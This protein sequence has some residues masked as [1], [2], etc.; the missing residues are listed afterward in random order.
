MNS[1]YNFVINKNNL[2][3]NIENLKSSFSNYSDVMIDLSNNAFNHGLAIV[4]DYYKWGINNY[5][6]DNLT[7]AIKIRS[8]NRYIGIWCSEKI[9]L[10]YI[11]DAINN[12]IVVRIYSLEYLED[13]QGLNLKDDL[14]IEL[15]ISTSKKFPGLKNIKDF[16]NA[17]KIVEQEKHLILKSVT[18]I[19]DDS[20]I[21]SLDFMNQ[22]NEFYKYVKLIDNENIKIILDEKCAF[23]KKRNY[24]NSMV[25]KTLQYGLIINDSK[26]L[27]QKLKDKREIKN[28]NLKNNLNFQL[29]P[30]FLI[31]SY[32][33]DK[34]V[35]EKKEVFLNYK[36]KE[37]C[38]IGIV[39]IGKKIGLDETI[40]YVLINEKKCPILKIEY[41]YLY[42]ILN[43]ENHI[44][45]IVHLFGDNLLDF[46]N[47]DS[48]TFMLKFNN[49]CKIK[50]IK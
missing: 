24:V 14:K 49:N 40:E 11:Y 47:G 26:N 25:L 7:E 35:V 36:F 15:L 50:Y 38:E 2:K 33:L 31:E 17:L 39:P 23:Y 43:D 28:T 16:K 19:L 9:D 42:V 30:A 5:F 34:F 22:T 46:A 37:N 29:K 44:G 18:T 1:N 32:V 41:D 4:C 3:H 13:I 27:F 10:D 20:K 45:E 12:D 48:R 6:L 21:K 8:F